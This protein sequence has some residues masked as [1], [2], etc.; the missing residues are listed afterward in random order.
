MRGGPGDISEHPASGRQR[1]FRAPRSLGF[2]AVVAT[3]GGL[4]LGWAGSQSGPPTVAQQINGLLRERRALD[5]ELNESVLKHL[6]KT[7]PNFNLRSGKEVWFDFESRR[8]L[9]PRCL[10][11]EARLLVEIEGTQAR[12]DRLKQDTEGGK[13]PAEVDVRALA[14]PRYQ[15]SAR[16]VD[17]AASRVDDL[18]AAGSAGAGAREPES[19]DEAWRRQA[20]AEA[21]LARVREEL[22]SVY[23]AE[24]IERLQCRAREAS[25]GLDQI[26]GLAKTAR[27]ELERNC[28]PWA[29]LDA[30]GVR[31]QVIR[32]RLEAVQDRINHLRQYGTEDVPDPCPLPP[33]RRAEPAVP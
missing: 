17:A 1:L 3:A 15:A 23:L 10:E 29:E 27:E 14:D 6:A 4:W 31:E 26:R 11:Q 22:R 20:A 33:P 28:L 13:T 2:L 21:R 19:L 16:R 8:Q 5:D 32:D 18:K 30:L 9:V 12:L 25:A 7:D 24:R